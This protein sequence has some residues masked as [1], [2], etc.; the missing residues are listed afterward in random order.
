MY[1]DIDFFIPASLT[2]L[3]FKFNENFFVMFDKQRFY[4]IRYSNRLLNI[5]DI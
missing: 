5:L 4:Y 2:K 1:R 3:A